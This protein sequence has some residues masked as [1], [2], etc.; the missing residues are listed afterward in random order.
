MQL[1]KW[2]SLPPQ[3]VKLKFSD[4]LGK[5]II[6]MQGYKT[7]YLQPQQ[8][9]PAVINHE[10]EAYMTLYDQIDNNQRKAPYMS[11]Y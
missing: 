4:F 10:H 8:M 2:I 5:I 6:I 9:F 11:R 7:T 3:T 1:T